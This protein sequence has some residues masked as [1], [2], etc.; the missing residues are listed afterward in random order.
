MK[1]NNLPKLILFLAVLSGIT[2]I[3]SNNCF[4]Q[5]KHSLLSSNKISNFGKHNNGQ[6]DLNFQNDKMIHHLAKGSL[7]N[8]DS[9][10]Y[11]NWDSI[12][13]NWIINR[14]TTYTY[15][16]NNNR[17]SVLELV[18][19]GSIW[20]NNYKVTYTYDTT[21]NMISEQ[22]QIWSGTVWRNNSKYTYTYDTTNKMTSR[23]YQSWSGTGWED[24]YKSTYTYDANNKLTSGLYQEWSGSVWENAYKDTLTYDPNN[25]MTSILDQEWSGTGWENSMKFTY[26]YDANNNMKSELYQD[27]SGTAWGNLRQYTYSY[28]ANN[29]MTIKLL[30]ICSDTLLENY[31]KY[32]YYYPSGSGIKNLTINEFGISVYPN[33]TTDKI[34]VE[35]DDYNYQKFDIDF[36]NLSGLLI[37]TL[38]NV[39]D[40]VVIINLEDLTP[41]I[42]LVRV[43]FTDG[44]FVSKK[45][46][47]I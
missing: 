25:N 42:Y 40:K 38:K 9:S 34:K 39:N 4:A 30:Q 24:Y 19:S 17:T 33:P 1:K 7:S 44:A 28:D 41:G 35:I 16:A 27:W 18:W 10:Y 47:K 36:F 6:K 20:E 46:I 45:I 37:K 32:T 31:G 13:N 8:C 14:R 29:N 22:D 23:L 2:I 15:D 43:I 5:N 26:T 11:W 3:I 21:N 12:S